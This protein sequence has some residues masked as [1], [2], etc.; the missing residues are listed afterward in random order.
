MYDI[1]ADETI[2]AE[3][4]TMR[5]QAIYSILYFSARQTCYR[6]VTDCLEP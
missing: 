6:L 1:M 4:S 3:P 2:R 5:K